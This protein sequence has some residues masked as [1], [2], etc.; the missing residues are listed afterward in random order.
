MFIVYGIM[1]F[2]I[3]LLRDDNPF[4]IGHLTISQLLGIS[5][6]ILGAS[7]LAL[8]NFLKAETLPPD[9]PGPKKPSK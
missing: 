1:R 2:L 8:F 4:E 9:N 6:V 3:E 5:L 7:L